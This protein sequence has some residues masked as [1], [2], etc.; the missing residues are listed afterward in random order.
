MKDLR[1]F[2][3]VQLG[4]IMMLGLLFAQ[5]TIFR[6]LV[7]EGPEEAHEAYLAQD[8]AT[9][10]GA[11]EKYIASQQEKDRQ[12][13]DLVYYRAGLS[14][15]PLGDAAATIA[16]LDRVRHSTL[17]DADVFAAL[18]GAFRQVDNLS[19]EITTLTHYVAHFPDGPHLEAIQDRLFITLVKSRN[20]A[21]ALAIWPEVAE[22]AEKD[23]KL[24]THY[25]L[26][27]REMGDAAAA[28]ET[29]R[30]LLDRDPRNIQALDWL[31]RKHFRDANERYRRA[32][33]AYEC[34]RTHRQYAQ[35]LEEYEIMNTDLRIA[36]N[37]FLRLYDLAPS[38]AYAR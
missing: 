30:M 22:R 34:N 23:K 20:Y 32:N 12:V 25:F 31:A 33:E 16:Y 4:L 21:D 2:H 7:H 5:C 37:Y 15:H 19:R 10:L 1:R 9:A 38:A 26:L 17:A 36:L 27:K 3:L 13:D 28:T 24:L 18:A 6:G 29:A 14:A 35:L 8:Y 11:Y